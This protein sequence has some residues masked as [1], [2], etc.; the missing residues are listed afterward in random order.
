MGPQQMAI[1]G[2][3]IFPWTTRSVSVCWGCA[4][5]LRTRI[6]YRRFGTRLQGG[7]LRPRRHGSR[8]T[9]ASSPHGG[10]STLHK[11]LTTGSS[12]AWSDGR[13]IVAHGSKPV[14]IK[15]PPFPAELD[16]PYYGSRSG[17]QLRRQ[18]TTQKL[19]KSGGAAGFNLHQLKPSQVRNQGDDGLSKSPLPQKGSRTLKDGEKVPNPKRESEQTLDA[20]LDY[21]T[22]HR[23]LSCGKPLRGSPSFY[24]ISPTEKI[25]PGWRLQG[26]L[27]YIARS[28]KVQADSQKHGSTRLYSTKVLPVEAR[29]NIQTE[30]DVGEHCTRSL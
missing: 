30:N 18:G 8:S 14:S 5:E 17:K 22:A 2:E 13:K 11:S 7:N 15:T 3:S 27:T 26:A 10:L 4:L 20:V 24:A 1:L 9:T 19:S 6:N 25:R 23:N 16:R 12:V 29:R 28:M 21:W